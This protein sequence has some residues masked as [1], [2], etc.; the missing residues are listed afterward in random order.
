MQTETT[1]RDR[2]GALLERLVL[3]H[4]GILVV[5][6][7]WC[8]GGQVAWARDLLVLWGSAGLALFC[9]AAGSE[10]RWREALRLLWPLLLYDALVIASCFNPGFESRIVDGTPVHLIRDAIAWLPSSA[11]PDL[12]ARELWQFNGIV[13]SCAN[14]ALFI[15]RRRHLRALLAV[16]AAN[17]VLLSIFGTLQKLSGAQG[18]IFGL[19]PTRQPYFFSTFVYHNHWGAF[20]VLNLAAS[21]GL[22]F[23]FERRGGHRDIWH[24]PLLAGGLACVLLAATVP[25]SGSRSGT[26][27]AALLLAAAFGH[28]LLRVIRKRR[29]LHESVALPLAGLGLAAFLALGAVGWLADDVIRRRADLTRE[30]IAQI[31]AAPSAASRLVLYADTWRMAMEKPWFGW[32]LETYADVFRIYNSQRSAEGWTPFYA[33]AHNDWFQSVAETG[34]AGTVLL[35]LLGLRPVLAAPWRHCA[36]AIPRYLLGGT[37][38]ILLYAFVEFPLA[39]PSVMTGVWLSLYAACRYATLEAS[40]RN[41]AR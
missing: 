1:E 33:E 4:L 3:W 34:L 6:L 32:G 39:N 21:L 8:F 9:A 16:I 28:F 29:E 25:L 35:L 12:S 2:R 24:S 30:Q 11:R 10:R 38:L 20:T 17:A 15:T 5:V 13:V 36:S 40:R 26:L 7:S 14:L 19:F 41:A 22:V 27:L 37:L 23:H 31:Q 18:L